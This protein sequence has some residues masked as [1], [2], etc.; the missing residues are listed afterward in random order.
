[1]YVCVSVYFFFSA[2]VM[3]SM[4]SRE[5]AVDFCFPFF[6]FSFPPP[7]H[8]LATPSL[9]LSFSEPTP[10]NFTNLTQANHTPNTPT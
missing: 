3:P 4:S 9:P 1:M 6:F 5:K 10:R 7:F 2:P 8:V